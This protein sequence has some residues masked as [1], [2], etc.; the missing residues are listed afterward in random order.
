MAGIGFQLRKIIGSGGLGSVVGALVAGVFIVAGPWLI[1]VLSM[2]ILQVFFVRFSMQRIDAFQ[3]GVVY[4]YAFSLGLFSG[5]HHHFTRITSDLVWDDRQGEASS[6]MLR[7]AALVLIASAAVSI[8]VVVL[9]PVDIGP[10]G[11]LYRVSLALLFCTI[12]VMWIL[13]LFVSL[14]KDYRIILG[15]FTL[16]MTCSI[17]GAVLLGRSFGPGGSLAGYTLGI[18]AITLL[19]L[20]FSLRKYSP[21]HPRD[22]W[23]LLFSTAKKYWALILSG[24]FFYSGQWLD[25]WYFWAVRGET[26]P[27]LP[28]RLFGTYDYSVYIAGLSVIPGLVYFIIIAETQ[29]YTDLRHFL[30]TLNHSTWTKIQDAKQRII[31]SVSTE[32]RDQSLLQG[33]CSLA[34]LFILL[35]ARPEGLS[36]PILYCALGAAFFQFTLLTLI[37]LLYYMELY[38]Q[39]LASTSLYAL[40]NGVVGS[41]AYSLL[42][43]L[44]PGAGNLAAGM[45]ASALAL[46]LVRRS[47]Y[48]LDRIIFLRSLGV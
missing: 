44:P 39:A 33:A 22:G 11:W 17:V 2:A 45:I 36:G 3:A 13:M 38:S 43:W 26:V 14:L 18:V 8:P 12:N 40:M 47:V 46:V 24:F 30:F 31:Q 35:L 16:G 37:V 23:A 21:A 9:I 29:L 19:L 32:L 1:S 10:H 27:G 48:R 7:F 5:V 25:K 34:L 28:F 41:V 20:A 15:V 6:W 42:P 4:S